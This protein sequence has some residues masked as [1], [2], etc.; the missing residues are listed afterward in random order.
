MLRLLHDALRSK[1]TAPEERL[2]DSIKAS[3]T[4]DTYGKDALLSFLFSDIGLFY[5]PLGWKMHKPYHVEWKVVGATDAPQVQLLTRSDVARFAQSDYSSL[6]SEFA[7]VK[8]DRTTRFAL[9]DPYGLAWDWTIERSNFYAH[10]AGAGPQI[11]GASVPGATASPSFA[12]W[13]YD[14]QPGVKELNVLRLRASS[15]DDVA[16]LIAAAINQAHEQRLDKVKAWNLHLDSD[17]AELAP[18]LAAGNLVE[19]TKDSLPC[20]AWYGPEED[21]DQLDW[22][23]CE[24]GWWC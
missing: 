14:H 11:W 2:A 16:L 10:K 9:S 3:E 15:Q 7:N 22:V 20:V 4:V 24:K 12:I 21:E 5:G 18:I 19:R 1:A 8:P 17:G 13:A 6:Q 23:A